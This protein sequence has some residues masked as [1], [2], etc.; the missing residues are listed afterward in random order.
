MQTEDPLV[1]E[2]VHYTRKKRWWKRPAPYV[3]LGVIVVLAGGGLGY[4]SMH[5]HGKQSATFA[6]RW[7]PVS[8]GNVSQSVSFSGTLEPINQ[9]TVSESGQLTS[10]SVKVGDK[11][12]KGQV[13]A[14]LDTTSLESQLQEANASLTEAQAKLAQAKEP[15][16]VNASSSNSNYGGG[17]GGGQSGQSQ[18]KTT[19]QSPDPNVVAQA[20]AA[21]NSA[22]AQVTSIEQQIANCTVKSPIAGTVVQVANP[23]QTSGSTGSSSGTNGSSGQGS[24]ST[25]AVISNLSPGDFEVEAD[26]AQSDISNIHVGQTAQISLS[27]SGGPVVTGKVQSVSMLPQTQSGVTTYPVVLTVD[28]PTGSS[29]TLLPGAQVSVDVTEQQA[30]DVLTVPTAAITERGG[31]EGVYVQASSSGTSQS[32]STNATGGFPGIQSTQNA[33]A[34]AGLQFQP[35]T[36]GI[37]GGNTVEVKS[38]LTSGEEVAI[39]VPVTTSSNSSTSSSGSGGFGMGAMTGGFG[40]GGFSRGAGGSGFTRGSSGTTGGGGYGGGGYGGGGYGGGST[41]GGT[42]GGNG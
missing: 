11:V 9:A 41:G 10:V 15:V 29:V 7:V 39:V 16:T 30:T 32:S 4:W 33:Q 19:T 13:I 42:V 3:T 8:R 38:G 25:I 28:K 1:P 21:V 14:H 5:H 35:I 6:V 22:Q 23:N 17:S 26:V 12:T 36:V 31:Q 24:S 20:Q 18:Q 40:G 27:S 34:M 37:Y 2:D